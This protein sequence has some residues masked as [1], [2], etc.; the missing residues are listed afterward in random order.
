MNG[1]QHNVPFNQYYSVN[2]IKEAITDTYTRASVT[3]YLHNITPQAVNTGKFANT[4]GENVRNKANISN[5]TTTALTD[6]QETCGNSN[7]TTSTEIIAYKHRT[8]NELEGMFYDKRL[9][10]SCAHMCD[11]YLSRQRSIVFVWSKGNAQQLRRYFTNSNVTN[12][13]M[14]LYSPKT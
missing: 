1:T 8:V 11:N 4:T 5:I 9:N 12:C 3:E 6:T 2:I 10:T 14:C 13:Q 7:S